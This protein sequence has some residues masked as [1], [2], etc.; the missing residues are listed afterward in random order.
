MSG[1]T[2]GGSALTLDI[3]VR[4]GTHTGGTGKLAPTSFV[5]GDWVQVSVQPNNDGGYEA[6]LVTATTGTDPVAAQCLMPVGVVLG[7]SGMT[8]PA[9]S[10]VG[11]NDGAEFLV[12][13]KGVAN[14]KVT[15]GSGVT[16][17]VALLTA[18]GALTAPLPLNSVDA[19]LHAGEDTSCD[20]IGTA[21]DAQAW[22]A[23]GC[24][25]LM[26]DH[27]SS[28]GV[29]QLSVYVMNPSL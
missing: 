21:A 2:H 12:R 22:A 16:A 14:A 20:V 11:A 1:Y 6:I 7:P 9:G 15:A 3:G 27:S 5:P 24:G 13:V 8:Y 19:Q 17:P 10:A 18:G 23:I 26:E 25:V 4:N 28:S 29:E